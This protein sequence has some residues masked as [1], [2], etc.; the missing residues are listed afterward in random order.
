MSPFTFWILK[1]DYRVIGK[2]DIEDE[3]YI[4]EPTMGV[5]QDKRCTSFACVFGVWLGDCTSRW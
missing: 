3:S 2:D 1:G 4:E 5:L